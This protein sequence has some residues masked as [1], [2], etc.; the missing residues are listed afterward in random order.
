M[1][2]LFDSHHYVYEIERTCKY[3]DRYM[4]FAAYTRF[5]VIAAE[6][7]KTID[8]RLVNNKF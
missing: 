6:N 8:S 5:A 2:F 4:L 7:K 3:R 1:P